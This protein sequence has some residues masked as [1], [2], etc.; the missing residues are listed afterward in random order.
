[1]LIPPAH[2]LIVVCLLL[3]GPLSAFADPGVAVTAKSDPAYTERKFGQGRAAP[4]TY[5]F[6][7]GSYF[8]GQTVDRSIERMPFRRIA[9]YL[10]TELSRQN[11]LPAR[12]AGEADLLLVVHWGTTTPRASRQEMFGQNSLTSPAPGAADIAAEAL[13]NPMGPSDL[14]PPPDTTMTP[15]ANDL[16]GIADRLAGNIT[17]GNAAALL[18]YQDEIHR[19]GKRAYA[20]ARN[21]IINFHLTNERYFITL[22]AYDLKAAA[23]PGRRRPVWT[24]H[25]NISSPGNNFSTALARISA[26]AVNFAGRT[27]SEMQTV[28]PRERT[29]TVTIAPLIILGEVN[30]ASN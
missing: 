16:G 24:L 7:Q 19:L 5:V 1:M 30:P 21:D 25:L 4:E 14:P 2:R 3:G 10:G 17:E 9:E 23:G 28:R 13:A 29:G 22:M 15:E 27:T 18:G 11:Y 8:D 26:V 6:L 20:D 12:S